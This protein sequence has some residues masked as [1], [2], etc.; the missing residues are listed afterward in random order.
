[1][2]IKMIPCVNAADFPLEVLNWCVKE[3]IQTHYQ[4]DIC[5]VKNDGNPFAEWLK[6]EGVDLGKKGCSVAILS[7]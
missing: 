5:F 1:M 2:A 6:K 3:E 4:N 7:T